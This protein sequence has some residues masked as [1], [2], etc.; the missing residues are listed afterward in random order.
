[1]TVSASNIQPGIV[2]S[3]PAHANFLSFDLIA[4]ADYAAALQKILPLVDGDNVV[5]GL[6]LNLVTAL[7][8]HVTD[9][10]NFPIFPK[11]KVA[12]PVNNVA[13]WCWL[14]ASER[15]ALV[16]QLQQVLDAVAGAFELLAC[17]DAFKF[18]SGRDLTG[19]IDGTENPQDQAALDA[20]IIQHQAAGED[21]GSFVAV[22]Q[23]EHLWGK[24]SAMSSLQRDHAIGR[25]LSDNEELD[26]APESAHVK[27]TA[28]ESFEPEAFVLRRSM[29]WSLGAQSGFYFVAFGRTLN[30]FEAQL[31]RM[32]GAEDGIVDGLFQ[33]SQPQTGSYFWCPPMRDGKLDLSLMLN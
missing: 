14:R 20:A 13:L 32:S 22:Q 6:G 30:A 31:K 10:R 12:L 3:I 7:N 21:G 18:D 8:K 2:Q 29:P 16:K 26:D 23:W 4:G 5:I 33:F 17:V 28:Q 27:R 11:S 9:L 1:M 15:G 19:Y 24:F 25:Q